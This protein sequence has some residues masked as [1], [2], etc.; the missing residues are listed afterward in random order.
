MTRLSAEINIEGTIYE[1]SDKL[2]NIQFSGQDRSDPSL[3]SWGIKSN[4]GYLE[5]YDTDGTIEKLSQQ[6]SLANSAI[7]ICLKINDRKEE[8]GE[9]YIVTANKNKQNLMI[10][11][12][13]ED[14][15]TSWQNI[16]M[17]KY[18]YP[19]GDKKIYLL[20][21]FNEIVSRSHI[22]IEFADTQTRARLANIYIPHPILQEGSLWAQ[23]SK[24]CE[25]SSCYIYCNNKGIPNIHYGRGT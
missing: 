16:E 20:N 3:P 15:L 22:K 7:N 13:F 23:M 18:H 2:T 10:K 6:G 19:Y 25:V 1:I 12:G 8:T 11:M 14:I 9:F 21:I 5:M 4:S 24:I 17:P